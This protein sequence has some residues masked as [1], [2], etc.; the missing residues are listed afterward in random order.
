MRRRLGSFFRGDARPGVEPHVQLLVAYHDGKPVTDKHRLITSVRGFPLTWWTVWCSIILATVLGA[1]TALSDDERFSSHIFDGA[2]ATMD[3]APFVEPMAAWG[4]LLVLGGA[5]L[6]TATYIDPILVV[7]LLRAMATI[8]LLHGVLVGLGAH[9]FPI[10]SWTGTILCVYIAVGHL[11]C[12][13]SI[14]MVLRYRFP[15]AKADP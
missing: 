5:A 1:V 9:S 10:V 4:W 7:W 11:A 3:W 2:K 12:A 15:K 8:Y 6:A 14:L 13:Q